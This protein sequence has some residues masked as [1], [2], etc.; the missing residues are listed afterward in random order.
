[1]EAKNPQSEVQTIEKTIIELATL[2]IST[3]QIILETPLIDNPF[4]IL[5]ILDKLGSSPIDNN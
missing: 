2:E 4:D 1:M 5:G 3:R